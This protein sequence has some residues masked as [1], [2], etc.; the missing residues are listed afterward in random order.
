M[1]ESRNQKEIEE[2]I[3]QYVKG[4]LSNSEIEEL[5]TELIQEDYYL[6]YLKSVAN[7]KSIIDK[8]KSRGRVT[9][10]RKYWS[11]A[12]AAVIALTIG[13]LTALNFPGIDFTSDVR[14][15]SKI[16]LDYYRSANGASDDA[17][18]RQIISQAITLANTGRFE[19]ALSFLE[20]ELSKASDPAWISEINLNLGSLYYNEGKYQEALDHYNEVITHRSQID[21]LMLEKTHWYMGNAYFQLGQL[22]QA[23]IS[24]EKAYELNGAYRRVAQRYL[25]ALND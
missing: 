11:Y 7:I 4:Q 19:E 5:W 14:P 16:E 15:V 3:D 10:I 18:G 20:N 8:K 23:R 21:M 17:Q 24:I 6:D 9:R 2:R 1:I 22:D 25:D 13:V 12:A